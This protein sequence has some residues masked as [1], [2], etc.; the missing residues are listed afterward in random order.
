MGYTHYFY[1]EPEL[2]AVK[3]GAF[4]SDCGRIVKAA[5]GAGMELMSWDGEGGVP[6]ITD[7]K[8]SFNGFGDESHESFVVKRVSSK[9]TPYS[10][11]DDKGRV[12]HFCK[13]AMKPYDEAVTACLVSLKH[14]F[15]DAVAVHSDGDNEDWELGRKLC[16]EVCGY[17][18]DFKLDD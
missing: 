14:H 7:D 15:G 9:S 8:V 2:D 1:M 5:Q 10:S 12:F 4:A 18:K 17:G 3:F 6:E 16:Q 11:S 13:T